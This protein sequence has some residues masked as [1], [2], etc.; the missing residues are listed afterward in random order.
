MNK[1]IRSHEIE[2][3][4]KNLRENKSPGPNCFTD[5]FYEAFREELTFT[6]L[7]LFQNTAERKT[8]ISEFFCTASF[9]VLVSASR[10]LSTHSSNRR[11]T[12]RMGHEAAALSR[13]PPTPHPDLITLSHSQPT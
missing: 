12:V 5:K 13:C 11:L 4:I 8:P 9:T 7:K 10:F 1:P 6:L 3:V 2:T